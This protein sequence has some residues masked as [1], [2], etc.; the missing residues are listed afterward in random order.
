MFRAIRRKFSSDHGDSSAKANEGAYYNVATENNSVP[1]SQSDYRAYFQ[2]PGLNDGVVP[3]D[4]QKRDG[5]KKTFHEGTPKRTEN[6]Q[7]STEVAP[8]G[9]INSM[10]I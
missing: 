7:P 9:L 6:A 3:G 10:P 4:V 2:Y 1:P 8:P 5:I